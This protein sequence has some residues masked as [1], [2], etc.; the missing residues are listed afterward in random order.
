[1][2]CNFFKIRDTAIIML[3]T[4]PY[5]VLCDPCH[6]H[7]PCVNSTA[8]CTE[9]WKVEFRN[10]RELELRLIRQRR[11]DVC[12]QPA[13]HCNKQESSIEDSYIPVHCLF[14]SYQ[15]TS[16]HHGRTKSVSSQTCSFIPC[17]HSARPCKD[18]G[19]GNK[20]ACQIWLPY[21]EEEQ[22]VQQR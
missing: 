6:P 1:M 12:H 9:N 10:S 2:Q 19:L 5:K 14:Y 16:T 22:A 4:P 13:T 21:Q 11:N 15:F 20:V 17:V 3:S 18:N 7:R 8:Q